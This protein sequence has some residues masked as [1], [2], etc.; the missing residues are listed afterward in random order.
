MKYQGS[1]LLYTEE[2][3]VA[4]IQTREQLQQ[5]FGEVYDL[6]QGAYLLPGEEEI[7]GYDAPLAGQVPPLT[8]GPYG[9][10]CAE[11]ELLGRQLRAVIGEQGIDGRDEIEEL[12]IFYNI[13][14]ELLCHWAFLYGYTCGQ[15]ADRQTDLLL[16]ALYAAGR[17]KDETML[18]TLFWQLDPLAG[19]RSQ[20]QL[21]A[22]LTG[23]E[24]QQA[25][26]LQLARL[27]D[28][29]K[30]QLPPR[31]NWAAGELIQMATAALQRWQLCFWQLAQ[32]SGDI[33][34]RCGQRLQQGT[35]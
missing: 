2:G 21:L 6:L 26:I 30:E 17:A 18:Q 7:A 35:L 27:R 24:R 13:A 25:S 22:A 20:G 11:K 19:D 3:R 1:A 4:P 15:S 16:A 33:L 29:R 28:Y 14:Q 5:V 31:P 23:G 8:S 9:P 34:C 12:E 10:V 32:A